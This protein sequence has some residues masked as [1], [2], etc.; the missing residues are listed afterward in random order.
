MNLSILLI[1]SSAIFLFRYFVNYEMGEKSS[2]IDSV[3]IGFIK[4]FIVVSLLCYLSAEFLSIFN[5]FNLFVLTIFWGLINIICLIKFHVPS[6]SF[7][8]EL[9]NFYISL[10]QSTKLYLGVIIIFI[11]IPLL[12]QTLYVP[13][14]NW[15]SMTYHMSRVEH[16]R[17]NENVYPYP[18]GNIRQV[19]LSPLAEYIIAN[20]QILSQADYFANLVQ[21]LAWIGVFF[22]LTLLVK[23]LGYLRHHQ[24]VIGIL[25]LSIP[26]ALFQSTT[27]QNDLVAS[28]FL[29]SF[30]YLGFE[31]IQLNFKLG[32]SIFFVLAIALGGFTKY[33]TFIFALPFGVYFLF[34]L[35]YNIKASQFLKL[36]I[37]AI[38]VFGIIFIPFL[39][40]NYNTYGIISG[41]M[42][43]SLQ[44]QNG[45]FNLLLML[46]N[47]TKI[48]FDHFALP[49]GP[50]INFLAK[51]EI[52]IHNLLGLDLNN[53]TVNYLNIPYS[54][55]YT[56]SE[57]TTGSFVHI[58]LIVIFSVIFTFYFSNRS[59]KRHL[60]IFW[61]LTWAGFFLFALIFRW[62]PW[63]VRL[64]LPL[65]IS[66]VVPT[67]ITCAKIVTKN[68][69]KFHFF[70]ITL[71]GLSI[72]PVY[73]N[74]AKPIIDPLG[75]YRKYKKIP[76]GT[77]T[78][79]IEQKIPLKHRKKILYNYKPGELGFVIKSELSYEQKEKLFNLQDSLLLFENERKNIFNTT[80]MELYYIA[81]KFLFEKHLKI[82]DAIK[83]NSPNI[84]LD[85]G[86]DSYEYPLW[87]M[88]RN[89]YDNNFKI[90]SLKQKTLIIQKNFSSYGKFDYLVLEDK[91]YI[92]LISPNSNK[93]ILSL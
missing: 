81:N 2:F 71:I 76:K 50:Y 80:R 74:I 53:S 86:A 17:Q 15:D 35:I 49:I 55:S 46:S 70:V 82:I 58:F 4:S 44:M 21:F 56:L 5:G 40:R 8:R 92:Q 3:R 7:K 89:K 33:T 1:F 62:Q 65:M 24:F 91:T 48:I 54:L 13:P 26:M 87:I 14:N 45:S 69:I 10:E 39:T 78:A 37:V 9:K 47:C 23:R 90:T 11:F 64:M 38:V 68:S 52:Q 51:I 16:W 93:Y 29:I 73:F 66:M 88:L 12:F 22:G 79:D 28:F 77:I 60:T 34:K 61:G 36:L 67:A 31:L 75:L 43:M 72:I 30:L 84:C 19:I 83:N 18:T 63:H 42:E 27:T 20:F 85:I 59:E 25:F 41:D 6:I 32:T 57:N